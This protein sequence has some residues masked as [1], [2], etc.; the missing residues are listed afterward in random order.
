M[1]TGWKPPLPIRTLSE[2]C[3]DIRRQCHILVEG[4][5][6]PPPIKNFKDMRFPEPVLKKLKAKGITKP[7][8][9]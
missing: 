6:T 7:T 1:L 5:T 3:D 4:E 9:I 8:P 2:E